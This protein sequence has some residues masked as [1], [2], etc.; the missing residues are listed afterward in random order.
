M[1]KE[2]CDAMS[3][4]VGDAMSDVVV[5]ANDVILLLCS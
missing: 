3:D 1:Y 2:W 4:M 5:S